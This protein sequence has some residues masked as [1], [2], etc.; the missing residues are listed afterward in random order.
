M[1]LK[2]ELNDNFES[3]SSNKETSLCEDIIT[4]SGGLMRQFAMDRPA[5]FELFTLQVEIL[6]CQ[7]SHSIDVLADR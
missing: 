7:I 5:Q 3:K 1:A 2:A 6:K 4:G